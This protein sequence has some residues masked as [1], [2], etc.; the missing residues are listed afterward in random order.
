[1]GR[2]DIR[3]DVMGTHRSDGATAGKKVAQCLLS[4]VRRQVSDEDIGSLNA[5]LASEG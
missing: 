5:I 2:I 4:Y 1:M 3:E